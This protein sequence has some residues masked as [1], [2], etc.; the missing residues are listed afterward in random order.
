MSTVE[1]AARLRR[2]KELT[3]EIDAD[4]ARRDPKTVLEQMRKAQLA[5]LRAELLELS[6]L[7]GTTRHRLVFIGKVGVG[8]NGDLPPGR[9]DRGPPKEEN[10]QSWFREDGLGHRGPDGHWLRLHDA[11]RSRRYPRRRE[12]IRGGALPRRRWSEP[13]QISAWPPG[14]GYTPTTAARGRK[15]GPGELPPELVRAVRNMVKLP[16]GEKREDDAAIR[17]ARIPFR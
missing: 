11:L 6:E 7:L 12:P 14:K 8:D 10:Q 5:D 4:F 13:S 3:T 17:L 16:E 15:G 1:R 9:L 2:A